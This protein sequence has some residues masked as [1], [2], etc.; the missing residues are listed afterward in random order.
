MLVRIGALIL[1][2]T[3][4]LTA[5][6]K[7]GL[8]LQGL[9]EP[10][11]SHPVVVPRLAG[12]GPGAGPGTLVIVRLVKAGTRVKRGDLLIEFDAC[13]YQAAHDLAASRDRSRST[14]GGE[15]LT[16]GAHCEAELKMAENA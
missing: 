2:F 9:I 14:E 13:S 4:C 16:A 7:P 15:Q 1:A 6:G 12:S 5:N 3:V 8:R 10:V 11:R